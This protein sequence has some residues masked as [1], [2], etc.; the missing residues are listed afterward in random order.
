M[1]RE[2]L[3]ECAER[4]DEA[5]KQRTGW[6]GRSR[7]RR[8]GTAEGLDL[9]PQ[10]LHFG[11][12]GE[13]GSGLALGLLLGGGAG[14]SLALGLLLGGG[15]GGGLAPGLLLG[16]GAGGGLAL[17][18]LLGGGAGGGLAVPVLADFL[19]RQQVDAAL[20]VVK[21]EFFTRCLQVE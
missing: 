14:G 11:L 21:P 6:G 5:A 12:G 15:A 8:R 1:V 16:G 17:G 18:L 19:G 4:R 3:Q 10:P 20:R 9:A 13:A 2:D 7:A